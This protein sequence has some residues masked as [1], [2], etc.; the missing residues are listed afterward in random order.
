M[1]LS[2]LEFGGEAAGRER[3]AMGQAPRVVSGRGEGCAGSVGGLA[4]TAE[5]VGD[6]PGHRTTS[7]GGEALVAV[8]R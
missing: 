5:G 7:L 1:R 2:V 3:L 8:A 6:V 4:H